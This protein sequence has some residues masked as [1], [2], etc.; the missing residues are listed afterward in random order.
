MFGI[1]P[2]E[3][4]VIIIV[5][6][7]VLGPE[8]LP[9]A[10]RM[11]GRLTG[12]MRRMSTEFQRTLHTEEVTD[13]QPPTPWRNPESATR[14]DAEAPAGGSAQPPADGQTDERASGPAGGS[15]GDQADERADCPEPT[16][17]EAG[18]T[19]ANGERDRA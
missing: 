12:E 10:A 1:G 6:L 9:A 5:A 4:L 11:L 17:A 7:V 19:E 15:A 18:A 13:L 2:G 14:P 3:L 8:K 16:Q